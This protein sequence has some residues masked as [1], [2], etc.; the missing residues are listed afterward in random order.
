MC[1]KQAI[2]LAALSHTCSYLLSV[3][4]LKHFFCLVS[5][6]QDVLESVDLSMDRRSPTRGPVFYRQGEE[7]YCLGN[8]APIHKTS[9]SPPAD[10]A[11][12]V[13]LC[14]VIHVPCLWA[15]HPAQLLCAVVLCSV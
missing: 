8:Q 6:E 9:H 15:S 5:D 2:V 4:S 1:A 13:R 11:V 10:I 3:C 14:F 7:P 12:A